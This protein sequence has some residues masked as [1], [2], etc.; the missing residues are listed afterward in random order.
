M[1]I[2]PQVRRVV[3]PAR[4]GVNSVFTELRRWHGVQRSS[5]RGSRVAGIHL[6]RSAVVWR[7]AAFPVVES[8]PRGL[9]VK[10]AVILL[11]SAK[12]IPLYRWVVSRSRDFGFPVPPCSDRAL[13][14]KT[15]TRSACQPSCLRPGRARGSAQ[16]CVTALRCSDAMPIGAR[17]LDLP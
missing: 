2:C 15:M 7:G 6:R 13:L 1:M 9:L 11:R 3:E 14:V 12:I 16:S 10:H 8:P 5:Q 4:L 17:N